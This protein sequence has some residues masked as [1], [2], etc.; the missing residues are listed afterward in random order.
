VCSKL[1]QDSRSYTLLRAA[2]AKKYAAEL[3]TKL[4]VFRRATATRKAL[5]LTLVTTHG[6][7]PNPYQAELVQASVTANALF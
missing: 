7:K 2:F 3:R 4:D 1:A 6:V 5:F